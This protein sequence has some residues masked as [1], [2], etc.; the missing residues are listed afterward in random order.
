M[1]R[2]IGCGVKIQTSNKD[3]P[4]Y[5]PE[6]ALI[7]RGENV[8]CKRCYDIRH[9]NIKYTPENNLASYYDKI[10]VIKD[11]NA[12]VILMIDVMDICGGFIPNLVKYIGDNKTL[13]LVNKTDILPKQLKLHNLE[14]W[15]RSVARS[16]RINVEGVLFISSNKADDIKKVIA[17]VT[18]LKYPKKES[19]Y[20]KV[21]PI[22]RFGNC[23]V[24]GH[25]SVG[26]STFMNQIGKLYLNHEKDVLTTSSQF[27]TTLDFIKWPLDRNSYIID[28]PGI[29]NPS[30]YYAY[31]NSE[32]VDLLTP[33]SYLKPR[34]YQLNPDQTIFL[35]GLVSLE[36]SGESKSNVS[37]YVANQLYIH[38]TKTINAKN[39]FN[40]QLGKMLTPPTAPEE[41]DALKETKTV[42]FKVM[43]AA[44]LFISGI[45]FVRVVSS[46][47]IVRVTVPKQIKVSCMEEQV[48]A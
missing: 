42:E 10:K 29:I 5:L 48:T 30:N 11:E 17:K 34:T 43:G 2:C 20:S 19:K 41:M 38:R 47:G 28:T 3:L 22:E 16:E 24:I 27:Q 15:V 9:H 37:F 45:G 18:K 35:G 14:M 36:F 31:L 1:S 7:E 25:S 6:S 13:I 33:K 4:G 8:Y 21:K 23:Y 12:L 44:N 40:T 39:I 32:S 26:K 46:D